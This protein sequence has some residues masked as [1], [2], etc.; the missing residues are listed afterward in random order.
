MLVVK[1]RFIILAVSNS[2]ANPYLIQ[3]FTHRYM[4]L[5]CKRKENPR[6]KI[7]V[8]FKTTNFTHSSKT[9]RNRNKTNRRQI[10]RRSAPPP[11][12]RSE[13]PD[14]ERIITR[15]R[16]VKK[17]T[18]F[19]VR[20]THKFSHA[21]YKAFPPTFERETHIFRAFAESHFF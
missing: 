13:N 5:N 8:V 1:E 14:A 6:H 2:T 17:K 21:I 7:T 10:R 20:P 19:I 16:R 9:S 18:I 3:I 12:I 15:F 4:S 11:F